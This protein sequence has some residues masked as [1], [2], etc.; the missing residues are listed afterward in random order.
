MPPTAV[1][2]SKIAR[3]KWFLVSLAAL[4]LVSCSEIETAPSSLPIPTAPNPTPANDGWIWA[5]AVN[6][7]G[8]CIAGATFEV[9]SGSGPV[10]NGNVIVQETPCDEWGVGG[11]VRFTQ[12]TPGVAMT[13]QAS[14]PG[15]TTVQKS[16]FP[17]GPTGG[18]AEIFV[19]R[20][21]D[22]PCTSL[23]STP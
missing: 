2:A 9:V 8:A 16:M 21:Q 4:A 1:T 10:G 19:L 22:A 14:A 18:M 5:M 11:G 20:R 15:F 12:L 13:L 6:D 7:G 17:N 3:M 23:R